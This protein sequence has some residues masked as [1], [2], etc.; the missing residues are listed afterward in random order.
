MS[1]TSGID[2]SAIDEMIK[3]TQNRDF[4]VCCDSALIDQDNRDGHQKSLKHK[5]K[6]KT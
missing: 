1:W 6:P 2:Y 3:K 5:H 4:S